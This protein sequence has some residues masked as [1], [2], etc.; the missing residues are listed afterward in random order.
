MTKL[1]RQTF[2]TKLIFALLTIICVTRSL[3]SFADTVDVWTVKRNGK[4]IINSNQTEILYGN[5]PMQIHLAS[6]SDTDTLQIVYWTDSGLERYKW[7]YIFKDIDN[8]ILRK[9]ENAIDSAR[10]CYPTPCKTFTDRK[11]YISFCVRD[12][13]QMLKNK[14]MSKIFVEFEPDNKQWS[15]SYLHKAVCI[16][17]KD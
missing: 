6:F 12:L 15:N 4:T 14:S 9:F 10:K 5:H 8:S 7:F 3:N 16:I 17:S 1:N 13:K 11:N 2:K